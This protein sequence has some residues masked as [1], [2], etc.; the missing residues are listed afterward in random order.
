MKQLRK[1][2]YYIIFITVTLLTV[3]CSYKVI[4]KVYTTHVTVY[5]DGFKLPTYEYQNK[6]YIMAEDLQGYG[7]DILWDKM[8]KTLSL[9]YNEKKKYDPYSI[10]S[11][12][13]MEF[14]KKHILNVYQSENIVKI[15]GREV[16]AYSI[17]GNMLISPYELS[18][19]CIVNWYEGLETYSLITNNFTK[20]NYS[21]YE[22]MPSAIL[23]NNID[24]AITEAIFTWRMYEDEAIN[25]FGIYEATDIPI[26]CLDSLTNILVY[27][28]NKLEYLKKEKVLPIE[29]KTDF[30]EL[31]N[32]ALDVVDMY[33]K[34]YN[35]YNG[36]SYDYLQNSD[37]YEYHIIP[38]MEYEWKRK[39]LEPII[40]KDI[41]MT[42][43]NGDLVDAGINY[44]G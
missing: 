13:G 12:I 33:I 3:S 27:L 40:F 10:Y 11:P 30:M 4:G 20:K 25:K 5:I 37:F 8:S 43:K 42:T 41:I 9:N 23:L 18:D 34:Q 26:A 21:Y 19:I 29:N 1:I 24:R 16:E 32:N 36:H 6:T 39:E 7:Y 28:E 22:T 44:M 15:N 35:T 38:S 17:D 14:D 31:L 2:L